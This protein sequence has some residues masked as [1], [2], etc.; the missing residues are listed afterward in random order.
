MS[1][2]IQ[3]VSERQTKIKAVGITWDVTVTLWEDQMWTAYAISLDAEF[4]TYEYDP[5][6]EGDHEPSDDEIIDLLDGRVE[7][8]SENAWESYLSNY[9]S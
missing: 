7:S 8:D 1:E 9:Y 3:P 5:L 2:I 4:T 6:Y